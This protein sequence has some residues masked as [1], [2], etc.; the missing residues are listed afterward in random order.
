MVEYSLDLDATLDLTTSVT[1][2]LSY[3][4]GG[5]YDMGDYGGVTIV[6]VSGRTLDDG[7]P[8]MRVR[9][10]RAERMRAHPETSR[11]KGN[12]IQCSTYAGTQIELRARIY[13][14]NNQIVERVGVARVERHVYDVTTGPR[15]LGSSTID[16]RDCVANELVMDDGWDVDAYGFQFFDIVPG[17]TFEGGRNYQ[18]EW[19]LT[20]KDGSRE[21]L[22]LI[23]RVSVNALLSKRSLTFGRRSSS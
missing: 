7:V 21:Q 3:T 5:V 17:I 4:L 22:P 12:E 16:P 6:A 15:L 9:T 18:I 11:V 20:R 14:A 2:P 23:A 13:W 8:A 1:I 10:P 19:I